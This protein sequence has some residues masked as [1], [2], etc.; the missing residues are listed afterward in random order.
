MHSAATA[1]SSTLPDYLWGT[2]ITDRLTIDRDRDLSWL[3]RI[4][5]ALPGT[6][7]RLSERQQPRKMLLGN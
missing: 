6:V 2:V 7:A 4:C 3:T 5:G 1:R